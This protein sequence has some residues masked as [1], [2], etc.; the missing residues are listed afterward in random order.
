R[1]VVTAADGSFQLTGLAKG[2]YTLRADRKGGGEA[3]AEHVAVGATARLQIRP[4]GSITG[5]A[6]QQGAP[7]P[8]ELGVM[9]AEP[10]TGLRRIESFYMTSGQF[11]LTD[12]PAGRFDITVEGDG[13][14][15]ATT[16]D[17]QDGEAK[18]SV[19]VELAPVVTVTG[20]LV[21]HGTQRPVPGY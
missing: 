12:L 16:V 2:S 9:V 20:R 3:I 18:T 4:T 7:P 19:D 10:R 11:T 8:R 5:T 17:L 6:R 1:P 15:Q 21:E 14:R 13:G